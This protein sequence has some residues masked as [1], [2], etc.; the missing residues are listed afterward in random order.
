MDFPKLCSSNV[1]VI[2]N[3]GQTQFFLYSQKDDQVGSQEWR[4]YAQEIIASFREQNVLCSRQE[5]DIWL[6]GDISSEQKGT[7]KTYDGLVLADEG[8]IEEYGAKQ[9][10]GRKPVKDVLQDAIECAIAFRL[11][12]DSDGIH[13]APWTWIYCS[14]EDDDAAG[15]ESTVVRLHARFAPTGALYLVPESVASQWFPADLAPV[16]NNIDTLIAPFGRLA[17]TVHDD[18]SVK[19]FVSGASWRSHVHDAL[20]AEGIYLDDDETWQIIHFSDD[21]PGDAFEWPA[22]LCFIPAQKMPVPNLNDC[23][24]RSWFTGATDDVCFRNP[25]ATAEEWFL[26][27]AARE[28]EAQAD[29]IESSVNGLEDSIEP[30]VAASA[31]LPQAVNETSLATSPLFNQRNLEQQAAMAGIYPTPPDGLTQSQTMPNINA[32]TTPS[33]TQAELAPPSSDLL[34]AIDDPQ[35]KG[36][37]FSMSA[38]PEPYQ[39]G[40]EDLFGDV[41]EMEFGDHEVGDADFSFFDEPDDDPAAPP[42]ADIEMLEAPILDTNDTTDK[43]TA[44]E[45]ETSTSENVDKQGPEP[46]PGDVS[47]VEDSEPPKLSD[48]D[49]K[50][51]RTPAGSHSPESNVREPEK[52]LSPFG[53]RERLLP[54]P[55]PASIAQNSVNAAANRRRSTFSPIA[56]RDGLHL[57]SK[58]AH[59]QIPTDSARSS[60]SQP[61]E[62]DINLPSTR[63]KSR[64]L[65]RDDESDE[66]SDSE[67]DSYESESGESEEEL[68]PKLPWDSK[69]RKRHIDHDSAASLAWFDVSQPIEHRTDE[70]VSPAAVARILDRCV[71]PPRVLDAAQ[72]RRVSFQARDASA[73]NELETD[74]ISSSR[75]PPMPFIEDVHDLRKDDLVC[76]AQVVCEVS[77]SILRATTQDFASG[78]PHPALAPYTLGGL[79]AIMRKTLMNVFPDSEACDLGKVALTREPPNRAGPNPGKTPQ[80]QPRPLQRSDSM[81]LGPD[82]FPLTAPYVRIQRGTDNWE[83]LPAS[84]SF[85]EPLGLGPASGPK[86]LRAFCLFPANEDLQHLVEQYISDI[87]TAFE[88]CKLGSHVYLRN[89]SDK[90]ESDNYEDGMAPVELGDDVSLEG[91][92][93]AFATASTELGKALSTISYDESDKTIVIYMVNPFED[94]AAL[95]HLCA[96]FWLL[97]KA[98]RDNLPKARRN[99]CVG[100]IVLQVVP[101]STIASLGGL[102][103][104][105][106]K[107]MAMLAR[108][109]YDRC[110]PSTSTQLPENVSPLPILV[111]P[112][113]ELASTAPKRIGFQLT[114]EP[115]SD[116]MHEG[117]VLHLAYA[118]SRDKQWLTAA[119]IDS[120]GQHQ[121]TVTFCLRGRSLADVVEDV[122]ERTR[123]I[124]A[125]RQVMWRIFILTPESVDRVISQCWRNLTSKPR[126]Q[127]LCV[128]LS[129]AQIDSAL[130]IFPPAASGDQT[131]G[132]DTQDS[133]FLTP[134]STPQGNNFTSSPDVSGLANAP[135]TPAPS[136]TAASIAENDPEAHLTDV[137]DET[138]GVLLSP[139][140]THLASNTGMANGI[141]FKRGDADLTPTASSVAPS[142]G[143]PSLGVSLHWTIQVKPTGGVDEGS[144]RQAELTLRELLK[145][146]RNLA[147]LTKAK[148]LEREDMQLVPLHVAMAIRGASG[149]EGMLAPVPS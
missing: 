68:P 15:L 62:P 61:T 87:G 118:I 35:F 64:L 50:V 137:T 39:M 89:A 115:P 70:D 86:K 90:D 54:P 132:K 51:D 34:P 138:W 94:S 11:A 13:V 121:S 30:G 97:F 136:E 145:L 29:Q 142:E 67:D 74:G 146:Y 45:P 36:H 71:A 96:C 37:E 117:S 81:I 114:A 38:E 93:K 48:M 19:A 10:P 9:I 57:E 65:R 31:S 18:E 105:D 98:Y 78:A 104:P 127:P 109:V 55:V 16:R 88:S 42:P 24:W 47:A 133:A 112:S 14:R 147:L 82:Y 80:G 126:P 26:G 1:H 84:L 46:A 28:R 5:G 53:I 4:Q 63:K 3:L 20:R 124:M 32:V 130:Q 92:L 99:Q 108:E 12:K 41:G 17:K 25:L 143:L 43:A 144:I 21:S 107:Q 59:A 135:L 23:D 141:I 56:F 148:G 116:L 76:I 69:K 149:L 22:R 100:D 75:T 49:T 40:Q 125:A 44:T 122:W 123:E 110:P 120:T 101:I 79:D 102:V 139:K 6:F 60:R 58:Y 95:Q 134:A 85:W 27:A 128:T 131:T 91:A 66:E 7:M 73:R 77:T 8:K 111:A 106:A 2:E 113:V 103:I 33:V 129:S 140:L 52:P 72:L 83:M 119:W